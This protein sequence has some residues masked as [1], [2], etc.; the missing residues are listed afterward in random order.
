MFLDNMNLMRKSRFVMFA[1]ALLASSTA[2]RTLDDQVLPDKVID[3]AAV[4]G[5]ATVK[6]IVTPKPTPKA[7]PNPLKD[8]FLK[9]H[10]LFRAKHCTPLL[11]W[12]DAV[13]ASV[14]GWAAKC[15]FMHDPALRYGENLF[16]MGMIWKNQTQIAKQAVGAWYSEVK[17]INW[18]NPRWSPTTGHALQLL[19]KGTTQVGCA[20]QYC[21]NKWTFVA[22]R[23]NP[24]GNV[25][26]REKKNVRS[27][28]K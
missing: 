22:C 26:G 12:S 15:K 13:A 4:N 18:K 24:P 25:Q 5:E 28:C 16:M 8:V 7:T 23:Y 2:S 11:V 10:N 21:D 3:D 19:W 1:L 14:A 20:L 6:A 27:A 17:N 9:E